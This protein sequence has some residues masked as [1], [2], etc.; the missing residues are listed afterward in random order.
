MATSDTYR[1][2][3]KHIADWLF[4]VFGDL[5]IDEAPNHEGF[6]HPH[7]SDLIQFLKAK[8]FS[9]YRTEH[10]HNAVKKYSPN[11]IDL[12]TVFESEEDDYSCM[13]T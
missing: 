6:Y 9:I 5:E 4:D 3:R 13:T 12:E 7:A 10:V 2:K 8:G 11:S 1:E